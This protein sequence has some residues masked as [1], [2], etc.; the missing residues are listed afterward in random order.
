MAF[1][2]RGYKKNTKTKSI[3]GCSFSEFKAH[4]ENQFTQGMSWNNRPL[5]HIDHIIPMAT[6]KTEEDV[7][8]LNHY[9]NLRPLWAEEN[10]KKAQN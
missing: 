5:W 2:M 6:A 7:I 3:L 10:R 8:K 9:K 1:K 4:M